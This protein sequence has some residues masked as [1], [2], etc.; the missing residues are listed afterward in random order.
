MTDDKTDPEALYREQAK[1]FYNQAVDRAKLSA[2]IQ[3]DY[4][5]WLVNTLWL[6]HSGAIVGLLFRATTT[7]RPPYFSELWWF[8][9]GV[10]FAFGAG[11]ASWWNFTFAVN[12]YDQWA[13]PAILTDRTKWPITAAF[14]W[15]IRVTMWVA[16]VC[17][18]LSMGCLIL[19][20]LAVYRAWPVS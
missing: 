5:K 2:T 3:A 9:F 18:L 4:G 11:F 7:G 17:G 15:K 16:I 12:Q 6:M 19:G 20:A 8:I 10:A 13:S 1:L 14:K